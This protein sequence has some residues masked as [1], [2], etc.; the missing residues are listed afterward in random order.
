MCLPISSLGGFLEICW[1]PEEVEFYAGH[2]KRVDKLAIEIKGKWLK[3]KAFFFLVL[4]A[5]TGNGPD[6][7]WFFLL[8]LF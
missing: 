1:N 7:G 4:S 6:L 5:T 2:S 3:Q 8:R